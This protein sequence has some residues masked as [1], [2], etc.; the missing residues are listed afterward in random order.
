[1]TTQTFIFVHDQDIVIDYLSANKFSDMP[2]LKYVFLGNR[3]VDKIRDREDVIIARE[4]PNNIESNRMLVAWTGW[5]AVSENGHVNA[6]LVNLFE[7]D[8]VTKGKWE[9]SLRPCGYI[10][11]PGTDDIWWNYA[12]IQ[13]FVENAIGKKRA[14][15]D[16]NC[17]GVILP[18]TSNYTLTAELL[19]DFV[20]E[21]KSI[22]YQNELMCGHIIERHCSYY[23]KGIRI[24]NGKL[25][26]F[27]ADSHKTQGGTREY[28]DLKQHLIKTT[29]SSSEIV[30]QGSLNVAEI[31]SLI[32][33][34]SPVF[35]E[36]GANCGQTTVELIRLFPGATIHCFE[37]DPRAA[38]K[39][40]QNIGKRKNVILHECAIGDTIGEI[41]FN[42]SDGLEHTQEFAEGWD[43][44]GSIK[45]PKNHLQIYPWVRFDRTIKVPVTTLDEWAKENNINHIDFIWADVQGAEAEMINGGKGILS[46][47]KYLYTEY[48]NDEHYDGQINLEGIK[49]ALP[50]F[51]VFKRFKDDILLKNKQ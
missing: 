28:S 16:Q 39:F 1:M 50:S 15:V 6:D 25:S 51:A 46:K 17:A 13:P 35:V 38:A 33:K 4:Q 44:S 24:N 45:K 9:Q 11:H 18:M 20:E 30:H 49:Q 5:Y 43:H 23:F 27:Y 42:Q 32:K 29:E 2:N 12:G 40:K 36:I 14:E 3:P 41:E 48:S 22:T 19:N 37:P 10:P 47:T 34:S 31:K 26:H 7:Y 8:I 21:M